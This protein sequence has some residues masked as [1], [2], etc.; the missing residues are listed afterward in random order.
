MADALADA[1]A[2][3]MYPAV[4][5][6]IS[7]ASVEDRQIVLAEVSENEP[8]NKPCWVKD[9]GKYKGTYVRS[10]DGDRLLKPYEI[11]R[12]E[13]NK[14][15]PRWDIEVVQSATFDDLDQNIVRGILTRERTIH[16]AVFSSLPDEDALVRL[17]ILTRD[18]HGQIRPTLAG[19]LS[20]GIYPQQYFPR[21]NVTFSVYPGTDRSST[22]N[23]PRFQDNSSFVGPIPVMVDQ[24][25]QAVIKNMRLGGIIEGSFR[26]DLPDYPPI[27]VREAVTNALM[28][29]D[30]SPQAL[31]SQVQVNMFTDRLEI[32]N[33]GGLFGAVTV[34]TL[35][36][37][38]LSSSRN[39]HLSRILEVTPINAGEQGFVAENRGTGYVEIYHQLERQLLP[40]PT[41]IDTLTL[42]SIEFERRRHTL[43]E[44]AASKKGANRES[45]LRYL[46][47]HH[48]A[49]V[50]ELA[51]TAGLS[52]NGV[53]RILN[54]LIEEDRVIRTEPLRSPKQRYRLLP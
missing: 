2:E 33:P 39:Q 30:Y 22:D 35:G 1:C 24:T 31:G 13:E 17:G 19:L 53:R 52:K 23:G 44:L 28:H 43:P 20:T 12:L 27:A 11:D 15:Q 6:Q 32:I 21:L 4:R 40:P 41:I 48:T 51:A 36:K 37:S 47:Q 5:A 18:E 54:Q 46:Q 26:H 14:S 25:V 29:R 49:S 45:L 10:H 42:F 8:F 7:I 38:G 50:A 3:K 9:Q 16:A 34:E